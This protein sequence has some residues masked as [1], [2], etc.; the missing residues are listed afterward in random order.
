LSLNA[1]AS[2]D[3]DF[4]GNSSVPISINK[5]LVRMATSS[6]YTLESQVIPVHQN[7]FVHRP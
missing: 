4:G 7:K 6:S 5:L 2:F 3:K 1:T